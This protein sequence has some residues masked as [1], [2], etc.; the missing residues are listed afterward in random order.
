MAPGKK[1]RFIFRTQKNRFY[2]KKNSDEIF[3]DKQVTD[4]LNPNPEDIDMKDGDGN[5][6]MT[7]MGLLWDIKKKDKKGKKFGTKRKAK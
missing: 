5:N 4:I 1:V 2:Q 6:N 3:P 7:D